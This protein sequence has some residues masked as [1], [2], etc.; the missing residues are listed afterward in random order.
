MG[1]GVRSSQFRQ[2]VAG[3]AGGGRGPHPG[4]TPAGDDI[5]GAEV[6]PLHPRQ[7]GQ[8]HGVELDQIPGL[9]RRGAPCGLRTA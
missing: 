8:V 6:A 5:D 9:R 3:G 2:E 7:R 4:H 1:N